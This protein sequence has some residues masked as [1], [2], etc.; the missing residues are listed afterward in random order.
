MK[1]PDSESKFPYNTACI[2]LAVGLALMLLA[3]YLHNCAEVMGSF[4][5]ALMIVWQ[6]VR[7]LIIKRYFWHIADEKTTFWALIA[8]ILLSGAMLWLCLSN[9]SQTTPV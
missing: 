5:F 1:L 4:M 2:A 8:A 6:V 7:G 9:A 3:A